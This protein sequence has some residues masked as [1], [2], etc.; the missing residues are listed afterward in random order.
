MV[1]SLQ[2]TPLS[3]IYHMCSE[4]FGGRA[5]SNG[6]PDAHPVGP[7]GSC[8]GR[9]STINLYAW[10]EEGGG[11]LSSILQCDDPPRRGGCS[12]LKRTGG[13]WGSTRGGVVQDDGGMRVLRVSGSRR[14]PALLTMPLLTLRRL[15]YARMATRVQVAVQ[16][17]VFRLAGD[18]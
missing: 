8:R 17:A 13:G 15:L 3:R 16:M 12:N 7:E 2:F 10:I 18:R 5:Y 11:Q 4:V 6:S 9:G 14:P 1:R